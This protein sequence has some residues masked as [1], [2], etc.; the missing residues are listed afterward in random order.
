MIG[1]SPM[2]AAN[3]DPAMPATSA[4]KRPGLANLYIA[5]TFAKTDPSPG[6]VGYNPVLDNELQRLRPA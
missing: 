2:S 1:G 6:S 5:L 4:A 3:A